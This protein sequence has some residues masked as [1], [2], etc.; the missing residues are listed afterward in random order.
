ML[1]R[2]APGLFV[3]LWSTGFLAT[4]L[5]STGAEPFTFLVVRFIAVLAVLV[6]AALW[7]K[8]SAL[9]SSGRMHA[10]VVGV[11]MYTTYLGGVMWAMRAGM[12]SS[13][14]A[15]IVSLQPVLTA[16]LAGA[17]LGEV[18]SKRQ[19]AGI[20]LGLAGAGLVIGPRLQTQATLDIGSGI[21]PATILATTLALLGITLGT[22]YQKRFATGGSLLSGAIWQYVGALG[23]MLPLAY[24]FERGHIEWTPAVAGALAWL[25]L[26]LSIGAMG[27]LMLLIRENAV[28][29]ITGLFYLVPGVTA[30]MSFGLFAETLSPTQLAGLVVVTVAVVLMQPGRAKTGTDP[31]AAP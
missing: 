6:P 21:S 27:L 11:L 7:F 31:I 23:A 20:V 24:L 19:W 25:V 26:V 8:P 14:A 1:S 16:A 13:V 10:M 30:L 2:I 9:G 15:L 3:L 18:I 5:G 4:K 29:G 22:I 12:G 28:S 17:F